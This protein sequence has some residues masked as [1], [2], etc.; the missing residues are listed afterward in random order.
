MKKKG[1][2][3][4]FLRRP[5]ILRRT[6]FSDVA[7]LKLDARALAIG[8]L[9]LSVTWLAF[10]LLGEVL[11]YGILC[12]SLAEE[13][14]FAILSGASILFLFVLFF[15]RKE[16]ARFAVY[17][18]QF[19]V[20]AAYLL[21]FSF[22][23]HAL[24]GILLCIVLPVCVY[25]AFP[26]NISLA[27]GQSVVLFLLRAFIPSF[28]A[29]PALSFEEAAAFFFLPLAF[30]GLAGLFFTFRREVDKARERMLELT[31]LNLSYQDYSAT[32][33]EQSALDE[34]RRI[35]RDI[36]DTVGYALTNAIMMME[37]AS[38]MSEKDPGKVAE[39][40]E[41]ARS[42]TET[43]LGEVREALAGLRKDDELR[44]SGPI[45]ISRTVRVFRLATK[46][47]VE[48]DFGNFSWELDDERAR[49]AYHF[50]Q[51]GMLNAFNHGKATLIRVSLRVDGGD[52]VIAIRDNGRGAEKVEEGIGIKGA[53]ERLERVGGR[54]EYRNLMDGFLIS[55]RMPG[56]RP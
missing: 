47:D 27:A 48:L 42:G 16:R 28:I 55:L 2:R 21:I 13:I 24:A 5:A 37:A 41:R 17:A 29:K 34:R 26:L 4:E 36:H 51:E 44:F 53:R 39:F 20:F 45:A 32:V 22:S 54:L 8:I 30:S 10:S 7:A 52:L 49:I 40:M 31:K 46:T 33:A 14:L 9:A 3:S 56:G 38:L 19:L 50:I 6:A 18:L 43:A 1:G 15:L 25:E 12:P 11:G 35:S 23:E